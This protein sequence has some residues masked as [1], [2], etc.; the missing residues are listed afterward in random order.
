MA[1]DYIGGVPSDPNPPPVPKTDDEKFA[2]AVENGE[3]KKARR[4]IEESFWLGR[5]LKPG[6]EHLRSAVKNRDADMAR[7]LIAYKAA[8]TKDDIATALEQSLLSRGDIEFMQRCGLG[9][10]FN[11]AAA[12]Q[13]GAPEPKTG[14]PTVAER[15]RARKDRVNLMSALQNG[16]M[17]MAVYLR[18]QGRDVDPNAF[19]SS[20]AVKIA[21]GLFE[22]GAC[23]PER[24]D[25]KQLFDAYRENAGGDWQTARTYRRLLEK[26]AKAGA[27]GSGINPNR[28]LGHMHIETAHWLFTSGICKPEQFNMLRVKMNCSSNMGLDSPEVFMASH[29]LVE[30]LKKYYADRKTAKKAAKA[31]YKREKAMRKKGIVVPS[32]GAGLDY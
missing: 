17:E 29:G 1:V 12:V 16:D 20:G 31:A 26:L 15:Y 6:W 8:P 5:P 3:V 30:G 11:V 7:L 21:E 19:F 13:D 28:F 23:G 10:A 32:G 14:E 9:T 22:C 25:M 24:Y 18:R 27:D 2:A 4:L